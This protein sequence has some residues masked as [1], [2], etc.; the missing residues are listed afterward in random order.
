MRLVYLLVSA[1]LAVST[2][3]SEQQTHYSYHLWGT[4]TDSDDRKM[5]N[6]FV[7]IV[8]AKRPINGRIPC[9]KTGSDGN[10]GITVN[11]IPDEYNVCASTK[12]SPFILIPN[13]DPS[14]R[15]VCS[16]TIVLPAHDDSR[17]VDLKFPQKN[18]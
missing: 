10:F 3:P 1:L 18:K 11:D 15:V 14:H 8:P 16:E 12:E 6:I 13:K 17:K 5:D 9:V 2:F 7:C 4:V